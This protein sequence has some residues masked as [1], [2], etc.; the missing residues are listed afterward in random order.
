MTAILRKDVVYKVKTVYF[1]KKIHEGLAKILKERKK[2]LKRNV[3]ASE[4]VNE[5]IREYLQRLGRG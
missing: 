2:D 1:E 4:I 3:S 5:I